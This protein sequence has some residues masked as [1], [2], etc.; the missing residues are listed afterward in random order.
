MELTLRDAIVSGVSEVVEPLVRGRS[1]LRF[2]ARDPRQGSGSRGRGRSHNRREL[3]ARR[4]GDSGSRGRGNSHGR[5]EEVEVGLI[6]SRLYI[7]I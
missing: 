6:F 7:L 5:R 2:E 1:P 3:E 4:H